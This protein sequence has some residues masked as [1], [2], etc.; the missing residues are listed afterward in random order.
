MRTILLNAATTLA[1]GAEPPA[2]ARPGND[3]RTIR[4]AEKILDAGEDWR[5]LGT[6]DDPVVREAT[7]AAA[8]LV[9]G[10]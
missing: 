10:A 5:V 4:A 1:A 2:L 3:F 6:D 7:Q 9:H 8:Q